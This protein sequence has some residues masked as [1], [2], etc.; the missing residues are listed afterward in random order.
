[1]KISGSQKSSKYDEKPVKISKKLFSVCQLCYTPLPFSFLKIKISPLLYSFVFAM[2]CVQNLT[3]RGGAERRGENWKTKLKQ[4][5]KKCSVFGN[6]FTK[7]W[8]E[9]NF[10]ENSE[11][12]SQKYRKF[13]VGGYVKWKAKILQFFSQQSYAL[14]NGFSQEEL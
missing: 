11:K 2:I 9:I 10:L 14:R 6:F 12:L 7:N 1:M 3:G 8:I 5:T 4:K 13:F